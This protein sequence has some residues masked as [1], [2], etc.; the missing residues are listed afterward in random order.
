MSPSQ[1]QRDAQTLKGKY[2]SVVVG[3]TGDDITAENLTEYLNRHV[4]TIAIRRLAGGY[5]CGADFRLDIFPSLL[6][7][8]L[9]SQRS[10][11]FKGN[12]NLIGG[13]EGTLN[14]LLKAWRSVT[15]K[16]STN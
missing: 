16:A 2:P 15:S 13:F 12:N 10:L 7:P 6:K 5:E 11:D 1:L 8:Q 14:G 3:V 4:D 9:D